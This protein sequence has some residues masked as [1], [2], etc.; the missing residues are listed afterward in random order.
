LFWRVGK[1]NNDDQVTI[2]QK[3]KSVARPIEFGIAQGNVY[4]KVNVFY[5]SPDYI[6]GTGRKT[7]AFDIFYCKEVE[8]IPVDWFEGPCAVHTEREAKFLVDQKL[9]QKDFDRRLMFK[10][11][12]KSKT[13]EVDRDDRDQMKPVQV[14]SM[15][16]R[17]FS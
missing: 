10:V 14:T 2:L 3:F 9:F 11:A 12:Y 7:R 6:H 15:E 4:C 8:F 13:N 1:R 5:S 16:F 17:F